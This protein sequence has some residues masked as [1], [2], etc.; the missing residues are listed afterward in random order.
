VYF[1]TPN[2]GAVFSVGSISWCGSLPYNNFDNNVSRVTEN[3]L[4]R[5]TAYPKTGTEYAGVLLVR[6]THDDEPL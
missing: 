1:E 3:V 6:R 4:K 2:G 5:F